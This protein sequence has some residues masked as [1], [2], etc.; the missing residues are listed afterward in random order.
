MAKL[1]S[2]VDK[3]F[4]NC[5]RQFISTSK[6]EDIWQNAQQREKET[7]EEKI[8]KKLLSSFRKKK[9][10]PSSGS[11]FAERNEQVEK[12]KIGLELKK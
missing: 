11:V 7:L 5:R 9:S 8:Q 6:T 2:R 12:T 4:L 10:T 1:L 3:S